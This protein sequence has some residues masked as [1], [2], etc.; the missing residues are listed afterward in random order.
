VDRFILESRRMAIRREFPR[1]NLKLTH[2]PIPSA[3][4]SP[5]DPV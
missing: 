4:T 2:H 5:N 3:F 1:Q